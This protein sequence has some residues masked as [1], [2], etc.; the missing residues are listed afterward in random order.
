M[1]LMRLKKK[2]WLARNRSRRS[3]K[4]FTRSRSRI[5]MCG[6]STL[7]FSLDVTEVLYTVLIYEPFRTFYVKTVVEQI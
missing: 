4:I 3:I 1:F 2:S 5:K 6:S 7:G